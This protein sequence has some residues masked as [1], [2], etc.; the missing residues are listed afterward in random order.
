MNAPTTATSARRHDIDWLRIGAT[1]LLF[2]FHTNKVFDVSPFY[3]V[4]NDELSV[5]LDL[6]T[7]FIHFWHMPLFFLL[8]GWSAYASLS[9]RGSRE[10]VRERV[11]RLLVPLLAGTALLGPVMKYY[12]L[13]SGFTLDLF[14]YRKLDSPFTTSFWAFWPTFFTDITH[15][16][17]SHLWFLA[18]L[19]T[20]SLLY[21]RRLLSWIGGAEQ[22]APTGSTLRLW[23]PLIPLVAIQMTLRLIWPGGQNLVWD[24]AN[25]AYYSTFFLLG[26]LLA[27]H[28]G[29]QHEIDRQWRRSALAAVGSYGALF[30]YWKWTGGNPWPTEPTVGAVLALL[31]VLGLTAVAGYAMVV[32]LLALGH[33]F[34]TFGGAL[35]DYL[36]ESS[37]P[38]Y[39][40][41][42]AGVTV[43]G[44]YV[45]HSSLGFGA[46]YAATLAGSVAST[47]LV[48]HFLVRPN[49]YLRPL[50]GLKGSFAPA[51][52][53][54]RLATAARAVAVVIAILLVGVASPASVEEGFDP[55]GL[56][57]ADGGAAKV[58]ITHCGSRLCGRVVD[59]KH[60]FDEN[61][62][63]LRDR[64]NPDQALRQQSVA[65]LQIL[66]GLAA[67]A[68]P[69]VWDG[70]WIYDPASG[71]T[72]D[73][74]LELHDADRI[75]LRGYLRFS[76][77]GRTTT[78]WRVGTE[79]L[80]CGTSGADREHS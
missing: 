39:V 73:S 72:Y 58:E 80:R 69:G 78:W 3:H 65:G 25:F 26:F 20:F 13:R 50:V 79:D 53:G 59:L 66:G 47:M 21:R 32:L 16:T 8:A 56:W 22:F 74:R 45:V 24:W 30:A 62:C 11:T 1:Y 19:F 46:K 77:L 6:P 54:V 51:S 40:L 35:F 63:A 38:V 18:Y 5:T 49:A 7:L 61:G 70:G 37:M 76:L 67:T 52:C 4:K 75:D 10:F 34:L 48:Y 14:G 31:P 23:A 27:R 43:V 71:R 41:H 55:A 17:W 33:R 28:P 2:L 36:R 64:E 29:W 42:Q 44:F 12:E 60:P 68:E 57:Y 15:F 9:S